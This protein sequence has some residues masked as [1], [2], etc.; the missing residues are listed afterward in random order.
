M[1]CLIIIAEEGR[2]L[3]LKDNRTGASPQ[4]ECWNNGKNKELRVTGYEIKK[5]II[6]ILTRNTHLETRN[7]NKFH[8]SIPKANSEASKKLLVFNWL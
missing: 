7:A 2:R 1:K 6:P 4:L 5:D 3:R 8:Y